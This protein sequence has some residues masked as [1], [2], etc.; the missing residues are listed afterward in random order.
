M[1]NLLN[2]LEKS[3]QEEDTDQE[4]QHLLHLYDVLKPHKERGLDV[5]EVAFGIAR[6][7]ETISID[8][9]IWN[10]Y[11]RV[12]T[13]GALAMCHENLKPTEDA[14]NYFNDAISVYEEHCGHALES[15]FS[16][17]DASESDI[18]LLKNLN[19]TATMIHYHFTAN[20]LT[21]R[22]LG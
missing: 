9:T 1:E 8:A 15:G 4:L 16:E 5:F 10:V 13:L 22:A 21:P 17:V 3:C 20:L 12:T 7:Y 18:S 6:L 14:E 2:L 11:M 19:A